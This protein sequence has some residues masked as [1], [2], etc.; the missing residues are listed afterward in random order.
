MTDVPT[1]P[2]AAQA[3]LNERIADKNWGSKLLANDPATRADWENLS[4]IASGD[5]EA[6]AAAK[7]AAASATPSDKPKP[8]EQQA[9]E[10][11]AEARD[12]QVTSLLNSAREK[13]EISPGVEEELRTNK[14]VTQALFDAT[15]KFRMQRMNDPDWGERLVK[16]NPEPARE[17]FL[18]SL[19]LS[20]PIIK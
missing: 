12:R 1:T 17:L 4:K 5:S 10:A 9:A 16:G 18:M 3:T 6:T 19:I 11:A 15:T 13:F 14:P 7:V 20:S 8:I 2:E